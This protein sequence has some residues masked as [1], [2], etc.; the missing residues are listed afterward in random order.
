M[1]V[2]AI[3]KVWHLPKVKGNALLV[4]LAL[5][6]DVHGDGNECWPSIARIA[7]RTKLD[8]RTV[9]RILRDLE[10]DGWLTVVPGGGRG[11]SNRY[12]LNIDAEPDI[13]ENEK[14]PDPAIV[15]KG[16]KSPPFRNP[17]ER[18][19]NRPLKGGK[20]D[21]KGGAAV[22]PE[23]VEP[24]NRDARARGAPQ[25]APAP[26]V[27]VKQWDDG[28]RVN[29]STAITDRSA[30][31]EWIGRMERL[32]AV[33]G[34]D[35]FRSWFADAVLEDIDG[36]QVVV[37]TAFIRDWIVSRFGSPVRAALGPSAR[38]IVRGYGRRAA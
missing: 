22:P 11:R 36:P 37:P 38:F 23:P 17:T 6:D 1:S 13:V 20:S 31:A 16:G 15:G 27:I 26:A 29:V 5:A 19:A 3:A 30:Q 18:V 9:Q 12:V 33:L 2:W 24:V 14:R 34:A 28:G 35:S 21:G 7:R 25:G 4:L 8:G 32:R 10:S